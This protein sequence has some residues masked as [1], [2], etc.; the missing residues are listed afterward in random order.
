MSEE[1]LKIP[2]IIFHGKNELDDYFY[3]HNLEIYI[4]I[5]D[6]IEKG[7]ELKLE[8]MDIF[9]VELKETKDVLLFSL[10]ESEWINEVKNILDKFIEIEDYENA[11]IANSLLKKLKNRLN[12]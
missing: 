12:K 2:R 10:K 11:A 5:L 7:N 8:M 9:E 4:D 1:N 3:K 6:A